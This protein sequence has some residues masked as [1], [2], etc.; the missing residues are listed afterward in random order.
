LAGSFLVATLLFLV[1]TL[2]FLVVVLTWWFFKDGKED[3][4]DVGN[5]ENFKI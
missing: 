1:A 4:G 3:N 2:L 5:K